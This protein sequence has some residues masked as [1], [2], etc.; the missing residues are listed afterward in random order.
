MR[1]AQ[2]IADLG[3]KPQLGNPFAGISTEVDG[4]EA[5]TS[6]EVMRAAE[7]D[8]RVL[9]KGLRTEPDSD[10]NSRPIDSHKALIR[11]DTRSVLG[12]VGKG[13][14]VLQNAESFAFADSLVTQGKMVY[15]G[16]GAFHGGRRT[17]VQCLAVGNENDGGM[18]AREIA[19]G[20]PVLPYMLLAN[21]HDGSSGV[22]VMM[23]AV[24]VICQN[25]LNAALS[26]ATRDNSVSIKHTKSLHDRL[27]AAKTAFGWAEKNF[28][29]FVEDA[30]IL[31]KK[32]IEKEA[33]LQAYFDETFKVVPVEDLASSTQATNR[34][35]RLTQLYQI[36]AGNALPSVRNTAWAAL[37][38]VTQF[39]DHES[40]TAIRGSVNMEAEER[41]QLT[42]AR[43][44]ESNLLGGNADIK[45]RAYELAL[46]L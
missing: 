21:S 22:T 16:A 18:G 11:E 44:L 15:A 34:R 38:A 27:E 45:A 8:W 9:E 30:R 6:L 13:Y 19:E 3:V 23:T 33:Q 12:V 20:D 7:L 39:L 25:T 36:G 32:K 46:A 35:E 2:Y 42:R 10:G 41:L 28:Q 31:A 1:I 24:R 4:E 43:R 14:T 17:F 5:K 37:N 40:R 26:K 29:K